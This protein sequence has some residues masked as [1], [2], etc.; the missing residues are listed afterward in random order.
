MTSLWSFLI[1]LIKWINDY[2]Q[3]IVDNWFSI[4]SLVLI[5]LGITTVVFILFRNHYIKK[6]KKLQKECIDKDNQINSLESSLKKIKE[7][8]WVVSASQTKP[9]NPISE[10]ISNGM[11]EKY[12]H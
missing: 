9:D 6:I 5:I 2:W 7:T 8:S 1:Q 4:L 10:S 3:F 12:N 11:E